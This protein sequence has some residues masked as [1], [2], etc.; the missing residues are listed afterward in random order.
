MGIL[1]KPLVTEKV[2][3]L[4]EK[5]V[6]GFIVEKKANKIE[7]KNAI[8]KAYGVNVLA[9]RTAVIPGK[10][11]TRFSAGRFIA[12]KTK[13]FKKAFVTLNSGEVIDFYSNI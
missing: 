9:I 4:N 8:E 10:P 12:G 2:T 3:A 13:S 11:K 1:I 5:G 7:I 6:F